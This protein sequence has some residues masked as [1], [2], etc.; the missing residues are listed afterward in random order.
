MGTAALTMMLHAV[1]AQAQPAAPMGTPGT[2]VETAIVLPSIADEFHGVVAEHAFIAAHFPAWHIEYQ[3]RLKQ[4]DRDYDLLGMLKP[5][6][7]RVPIFF[8]ITEWVGK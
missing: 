1:T 3:T 6:K 2:T 4:N 7:T 8:D 5:D